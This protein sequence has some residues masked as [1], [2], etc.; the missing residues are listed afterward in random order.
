VF[1]KGREEAALGEFQGAGQAMHPDQSHQ[2][3]CPGAHRIAQIDRAHRQRAGIAPVHHQG[4]GAEGEQLVE[5]EKRQQITGQ[6]RVTGKAPELWDALA[7][8]IRPATAFTQKD[9]LTQVPLTLEPYGSV[10]V[11]FDKAISQDKEGTAARNYADLELVKNIEGPWTINFDVAWGGPESVTFPELMDWTQHP[12]DGIK[13][14]SGAAVYHKSFELKSEPSN[15][16]SFYLEL[17]SVK[18]V[19]IA[20]VK[21]NGNDKGVLWTYPFRVEI[22]DELKEGENQLEIKVINSWY[23][24]VAGDQI[25]P[26]QKQYTSTNIM[27]NHDYRGRPINIDEIPLESSGLLGPVTIKRADKI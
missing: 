2:Q 25:N 16:E 20:E 9:G 5:H 22:S 11:V 6:F 18:D 21:I 24:R 26:D 23:N 12:D 1:L 13:Y 17:G 27:M 10:L 7:G 14:Y 8:D 3:Y 15:D 4:I 19:G